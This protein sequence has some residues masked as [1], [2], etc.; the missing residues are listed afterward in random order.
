MFNIQIRRI[1]HH[2]F[3]VWIKFIDT[4]EKVRLQQKYIGE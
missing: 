4:S 1:M 3:Q 2:F